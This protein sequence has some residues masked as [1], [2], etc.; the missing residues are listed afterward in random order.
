MSYSELHFHLLPGVDDGP[1]TLADSVELAA[2]AA[3]EGTRTIVAT[4]HVNASLGHDVDAL[5][6]RVAEVQAELRRHRIPITVICGAELAP[7]RV[8]GLSQRELEI[9]AQGP[10]GRRWVLLE[11]P[12]DG[13]TARYS[14]AAD[15]LRARGFAVVLAH[16]ERALAHREAGW[17]ALQYELAAGSAMQVN[18]WS[19]AGLYGEQVRRDAER[20]LAGPATVAI[21]SDAHGPSRMPALR[22]AF[23]A[24]T[25]LGDREGPRRMGA[26][27]QALLSEGLT[28]PERLAA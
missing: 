24:L 20:V 5:P 8:A 7:E 19:V 22:M 2:A 12:L 6:E 11:A 23:S 21:A 26:I 9:I 25:R 14:Q 15:E 1:P 4:P 17:R 3:A 28:A 13:L 10:S 27:P 18:A 16:P